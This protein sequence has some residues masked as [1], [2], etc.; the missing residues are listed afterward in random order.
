VQGRKDQMSH[1]ENDKIYDALADRK[2]DN[3]MGNPLDEIDKLLSEI[4]DLQSGR[5]IAHANGS[6]TKPSETKG[7]KL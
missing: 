2:L 7:T 3:L 4:K 6:I 1:K 5:V